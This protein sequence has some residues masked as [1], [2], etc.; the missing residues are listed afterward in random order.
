MANV[1][2]SVCHPDEACCRQ[3]IEALRQFDPELEVLAVSD[4]R[5]AVAAIA[6]SESRVAVVGVDAPQDQSLRLIDALKSS[7]KRPGVIVVSQASSQ[8][9]LVACLRAGCDEFLEFPIQTEELAKAL[10]GIYRKLGLAVAG[11]G[12]V[13]AVYAAKGGVGATTLACNLVA[14]VAREEQKENASCLL[15]LN[16]QFGSAV[17]YLDVREFSYSLA[18]ACRDADRLDAP[19]LR[20][21]MTQH[22]SGA[23]LLP[24]PLNVDELDHVDSARFS[25]VARL[26]K[27]TYNHV[28]L[29]LPHSIE[30]LTITGLDV[31]DQVLLVCDMVLPSVRNTIRAVKMFQDLEYD[32]TKL[33]LV[34]NRY[35][36]GG[37]ISLQEVATHVGLPI[38]WL[39]PY[40]SAVAIKATNAGQT[41]SEADRNSQ[42]AASVTALARDIAGLGAARPGKKKLFGWRK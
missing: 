12:K 1:R 24:A 36:D 7:E 40:D 37:P 33:R 21:Y 11:Q 23:C 27:E 10:N 8:E 15:D 22:P 9:L 38:Y 14:E 17:L 41:F 28:F 18:D 19:M 5:G 25:V 30:G 20:S 32:K 34:V 16:L 6:S 3:I 31:A 39:V 13:T 42:V 35:Y 26:C 4:L 29:D 2:I